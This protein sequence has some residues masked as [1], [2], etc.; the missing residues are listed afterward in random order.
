MIDLD[1][2]PMLVF[3]ESTRACGLAC[4]HCRA[5]AVLTPPPGELTTEEAERFI[6]SLLDFGSPPPV[7]VFTGGDALMRPD[8]DPLP[9]LARQTVGPVPISPS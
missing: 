9:R 7:L 4:R 2:R 5:D 1:Q 3:W 8:L 6:R